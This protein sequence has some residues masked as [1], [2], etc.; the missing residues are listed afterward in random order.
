MSFRARRYGTLRQA[1]AAALAA[2]SLGLVGA[3]EE[4]QPYS[5]E[6]FAAC[7]KC[8][9]TEKIVGIEKTA[10]FNANDPRTPA[11]KQQC[12]SC[13]GPS[14]K[15]MEFP[16]QVRSISFSNDS[17]TPVPERNQICLA[18][19]GQGPRAHWKES[20]HARFLACTNCHAIHQAKDPILDHSFQVAFCTACHPA[21]LANAPENA[22]HRF[23][24]E[25]AMYCTQCHNP[26]GPVTLKACAECHKQDEATFAK[27]TPRARE[28][29]ERALAKK[30]ECTACHKGFVHAAPKIAAEEPE[31][32]R[33]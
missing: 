23:T 33:P 13:H 14:K 32:P 5:G 31:P 12:E 3:T 21:I 16:M 20:P 25:H 9:G 22:P 30:I 26:H 7:L 18:C 29:H 28:Y 6:G 8:H 19:H 24:G 4:D 11:A 2:V 1:L 10:H 15:H 27:Q 17:E